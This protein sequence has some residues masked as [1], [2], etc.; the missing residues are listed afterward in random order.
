MWVVFDVHRCGIDVPQHFE[1]HHQRRSIL[2][3]LQV[4]DRQLSPL[5]IGILPFCGIGIATA[6]SISHGRS[7]LEVLI[8]Q[9]HT[10]VSNLRLLPFGENSFA[11]QFGWR[12][13]QEDHCRDHLHSLE[14]SSSEILQ[15]HECR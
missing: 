7:D 6:A 3:M 12:R 10:L 14:G 15:L 11:L 5:W 8:I 4:G 2:E 9:H 1:G 13:D